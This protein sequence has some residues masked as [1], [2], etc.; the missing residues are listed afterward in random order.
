MQQDT[1]EELMTRVKAGYLGA[2]TILFERYQGPLYNFFLRMGSDVSESMDLTQTTF[3]R[4]LKYRRTYREG[5]R[6]RPWIYRMARNLL[7]DRFRRMKRRKHLSVDV[8]DVEFLEEF[9]CETSQETRRNVELQDALNQLPTEEREL[10]L[11]QKFQ[12]LSYEEISVIT[13]HTS[14]NLRL[15]MH[16]AMLQLKE[17]YFEERS[18]A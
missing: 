8:G 14:G 2:M 10:I 7:Y 11:M 9:C 12:G 15:R 5:N 4:V 17:V 18:L 16:R 3:E 13:G 1:D 6:F